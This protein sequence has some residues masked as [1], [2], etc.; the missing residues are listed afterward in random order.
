MSPKA[1]PVLERG[2]SGLDLADPS[3]WVSQ[4]TLMQWLTPCLLCGQMPNAYWATPPLSA[5]VA[6]KE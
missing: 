3:A 4:L 6:H 5:P 1:F 2:Y